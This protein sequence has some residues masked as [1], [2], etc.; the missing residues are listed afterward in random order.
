[1]EIARYTA[2][3]L[4]ELEQTLTQVSEADAEGLV[5]A[6]LSADQVFTAGAGRS[7]LM[8]KAFAMRLMQMGIHAYVVGETVTPSLGNQ[9][10]LI[11]GSGSGETKGLVAMAEKAKA[12]GGELALLTIVPE[13]TLAGLADKL[14]VLEA[15]T[16]DQSGGSASLQ[17]MASRFEQSML[18]MLD[19]II[20]RLMEIKGLGTQMMYGRHANL[21]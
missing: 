6:I 17:P 3:I 18:L 8:M 20:L 1:M 11:L 12:L 19:A 7:G 10:L 2:R 4:E 21:E 13:S 16:K 15:A 14:V 9:D 5:Q